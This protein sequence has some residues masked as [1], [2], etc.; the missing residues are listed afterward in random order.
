MGE[1][2]LIVD[3]L[4]TF[5]RLM[6]GVLCGLGYMA[7]SASNGWECLRIAS[8]AD[9]PSLILLD[10]QM[11][12]MTGIEVLSV[13]KEDESTQEIP[14]IMV[15]AEENLEETAKQYGANAVLIKPVDFKVLIKEIEGVLSKCSRKEIKKS[16]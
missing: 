5:R 9:K 16:D 15:S 14:V 13:L 2:I 3:D 8:S 10:C 7:R 6:Q 4:L 11:P 1:Y 12:Y